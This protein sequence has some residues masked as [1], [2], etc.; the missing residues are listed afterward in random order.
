MLLCIAA[1][2]APKQ[3][4]RAMFEQTFKNID[5]VLHQDAGCTSVLDATEQPSWLL[6][7]KYL[8][9]PDRDKM[10]EVVLEGKR[11]SFILAEA[12]R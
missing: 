9:A 10:A 2:S 5:D 3:A 12:L 8:D 4:H 11:H 7:L 6:L 1:F